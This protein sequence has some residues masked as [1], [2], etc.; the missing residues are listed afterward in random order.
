MDNADA[1]L[2]GLG[3]GDSGAVP[4]KVSNEPAL[5]REQDSV[6]D[7]EHLDR[8]GPK[9]D[10]FNESPIH[11]TGAARAMTQSFLDTEREE[12][13]VE[14]ARAPAPIS[15]NLSEKLSDHIADKFTDSE[16]ES[17]GESPMHRPDPKPEPLPPVSELPKPSAPTSESAALL[18]DPT[19]VLVAT[20]APKLTPEPAVEPPKPVTIQED[21]KPAT[22]VEPAP[23]P[24]VE[25]PP[26]SPK[27]ETPSPKAEAPS[28]PQAK[29][30]PVP[31]PIARAPTAHVIEAEVIFCQM[32]L[33]E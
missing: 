16:S 22:K 11:Y 21:P 2:G 31:A 23:V 8:E 1:L 25:P 29:P 33:G 15:E 9:R 12:L 19:P 24:K 7:F 30:E 4:A 27:A 28:K 6:D 14:P 3:G 20:P 5:K 32:G 18:D 13:F 17:A 10:D 26:P